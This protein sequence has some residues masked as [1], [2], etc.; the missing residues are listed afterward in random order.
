MLK[1]ERYNRC[2]IRPIC[3]LLFLK[4]CLFCLQAQQFYW[5]ISVRVHMFVHWYT[6][7]NGTVQTL[8]LE[9]CCFYVGFN[10]KRLR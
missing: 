7:Q 2:V 6:V 5:H 4:K 1:H 8:F 10:R 9:I 3:L